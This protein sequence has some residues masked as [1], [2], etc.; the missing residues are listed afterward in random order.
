MNEAKERLIV[1]GSSD[2]SLKYDFV[3]TDNASKDTVNILQIAR[4]A[5]TNITYILFHDDLE[6]AER[7]VQAVRQQLSRIRGRIKAHGRSILKFRLSFEF[8]ELPAGGVL[9]TMHMK[10]DDLVNDFVKMPQE[11]T[12]EA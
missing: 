3:A 10:L 4:K 12:N 9:I 11:E 1:V 7:Y 2:S 6:C 8:E 5:P